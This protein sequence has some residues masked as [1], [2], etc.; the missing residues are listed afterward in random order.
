MATTYS[1]SRLQTFRDCP[2]KYQFQYVDR[3]E[4]PKRDSPITLMGRFA[5]TVLRR[6][7][8]SGA[9]GVVIPLDDALRLYQSE[10]QTV[11]PERLVLH[12]EYHTVDDY[13]RMGCDMLE[14]HYRRYQPFHHGRLLG[15]ELHLNF[16][17][18]G[19]GF[20]FRAIIDRL[21]KRDDAVI[22]ISDYKTGQTL[23][24]TTDP[25]F[26]SQMG[27]YLLAVQANYPQFEQIELAQYFLRHDEIVRRR[28]S[29]EERDLIIEDLRTR[30]LETKEA[31]RLGNFPPQEGGHCQFCDFFELCP[32]KRHRKQLENTETYPDADRLRQ[33]A[34]TFL[35]KNEELKALKTDVDALKE[36]LKEAARATGLSKLVGDTGEVRVK[37]GTVEK[38][39][40]KTDDSAA[41]AE[42]NALV[43]RLGLEEYMSVDGTALMKEV[44][45]KRRLSDE[46]LQQLA[47]YVVVKPDD[48]IT[49]KLNAEAE[50]EEL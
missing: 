27:I 36:E 26:V 39:A 3:T 46:Q 38:F 41:W 11:V 33:L 22:E 37:L 20:P 28:M 25:T 45:K 9:D 43:R 48:R 29:S 32:A 13:I 12:S 35:S 10:W 19:S 44:Y 15:T 18:P 47:Q 50:S 34:D 16:G 5:H 17:L 30:V 2:R 23:A 7:Y 4:V 49:G 1:H 24:R 8:Q 42:L 21:W 31:A 6:L 14:T 40:T